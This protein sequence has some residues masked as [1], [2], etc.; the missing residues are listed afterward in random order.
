MS[1]YDND[2]SKIYPTLGP[3]APPSQEVN[4]QTYRLAKISEIEAYFLDEID[5]REKLAKK[6][7]L[8]STITAVLDTSLITTTAVTGGIS[9]AAL[10]SGIGLPVGISLSATSVL[11]SLAT[12]ITRKT[13][14]IFKSKEKNH[15]G[16]RLLAQSK[17]DSISETIYQVIQDEKFPQQSFIRFYKRQKIIVNLKQILESKQRQNMQNFQKNSVKKY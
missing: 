15:D 6:I 7:K 9:I 1:V 10:A 11:F 3:S 8:F 2:T 13:I 12:T 14:S 5:A 4:P 17:L 16:I